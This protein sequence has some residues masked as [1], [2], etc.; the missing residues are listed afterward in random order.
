M[1]VSLDEPNV[2]AS[3]VQLPPWQWRS[4]ECD[5]PFLDVTKHAPLAHIQMYFLELHHKYSSPEFFIDASK[6]HAGVSYAAVG[7]SFSNTGI[8]HP[9]TSIFTAE[10]YWSLL[11]TLKN[12]VFLRQ[13]FTQIH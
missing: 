8:L 2:M 1:G 13:L 12:C 5:V 4:I 10:A 6:S 7:R 11:N 3:A 9:S